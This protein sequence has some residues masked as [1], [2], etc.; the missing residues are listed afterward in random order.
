MSKGKSKTAPT[1]G[2]MY[3]ATAAP[4]GYV[5][6]YRVVG[7]DGLAVARDGRGA[8]FVLAL[9]PATGPRVAVFPPAP[10][11]EEARADALRL[12]ARTGRR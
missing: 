2:A 8:W 10:R 1:F 5:T 9:D 11:R 6:A 3:A 12:D 4:A 7:T